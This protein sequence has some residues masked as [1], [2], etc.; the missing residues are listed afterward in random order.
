MNE[1]R[2][3]SLFKILRVKNI[4]YNDA[5][6]QAP[7]AGYAW[8]NMILCRTG[9]YRHFATIA[10]RSKRLLRKPDV[11][12]T[13]AKPNNGSGSEHISPSFEIS[14]FGHACKRGSFLNH[15]IA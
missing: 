6:T 3:D 2:G 10:P 9:R 5:A 11:H 14:R 8:Q 12:R 13:Y 4:G 7:A 1:H 15:K